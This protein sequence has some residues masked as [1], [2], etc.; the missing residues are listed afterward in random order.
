MGPGG[1]K[2][3]PGAPRKKK[4]GP[5]IKI[6]PRAGGRGPNFYPGTNFF[7]PGAPG[8]RGE[9]GKKIMKNTGKIVI[10]QLP[11]A[12]PNTQLPPAPSFGVL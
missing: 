6:W 2:M 11:P 12:R 1:P 8:A 3:G 7:D 9:G 10:T 5:R 4:I